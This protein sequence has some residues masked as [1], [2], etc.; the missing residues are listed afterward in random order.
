[1]LL[2]HPGVYTDMHILSDM[3]ACQHSLPLGHTS[4]GLFLYPYFYEA[5]H[6]HSRGGGW[7]GVSLSS[8][9]GSLWPPLCPHEATAPRAEPTWS[10]LYKHIFSRLW[11]CLLN[12]HSWGGRCVQHELGWDRP[13]LDLGWAP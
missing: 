2:A 7:D 9:L 8:F 11:P 3:H 12:A 4:N 1:M 6:S 13:L 5:M 10:L